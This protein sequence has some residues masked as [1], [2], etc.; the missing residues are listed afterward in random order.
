[1]NDPDAKDYQRTWKLILPINLLP[2]TIK[3]SGMI[4][5]IPSKTG[6]D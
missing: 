6:I 2:Q 5:L 4:T 1:M 3:A